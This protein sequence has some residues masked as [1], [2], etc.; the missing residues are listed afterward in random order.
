MS[1]RYG[2][3]DFEFNKINESIVNLICCSIRFLGKECTLWLDG[4]EDNKE[5]LKRFLLSNKDI[6]WICYASSAEAQCFIALGLDPVEFRWLDLYVEYRMLLNCNDK[7]RHGLQLKDGS[8]VTTEPKPPHIKNLDIEIDGWEDSKEL[9]RKIKEKQKGKYSEGDYNLAACVYK[10]LNRIIDSD[11]KTKMRDLI[12]AGGPFSEQE[13]KD[14]LNYCHDDTKHLSDLAFKIKYEQDKV[15]KVDDKERLYR[16][17]MSA[18][19]A[20]IMSYGYPVDEEKVRTLSKNIPIILFDL[21]EEINQKTGKALFT[22][23]IKKECHKVDMNVLAEAISEYDKDGSWPKT[24]T[25]KY[26]TDSETFEKIIDARHDKRE[27]VL[28]LYC[29]YK[30]LAT[31]LNS[32]KEDI[33]KK[34]NFYSALGPDGRVHSYMGQYVAQSGRFQQPAKTFIFLKDARLRYLV[35]PRAGYVITG[36]DFAQQEF[37]LAACISKDFTMYKT[38]MSGDI[39]LQF[40][41]DVGIVRKVAKAAVLGI[42]Y[43]M[44][45]NALA[46]KITNDSKIETSPEQ[47]QEIIDKFY[48]LY[49]DYAKFKRDLLVSYAQKKY[50]KLADGWTMY[51]DN[52]NKLSVLNVPIQGMGACIL[53]KAIELA[54]ERGLKI[55]FPLHDALYIESKLENYEKELDILIECMREASGF[56]FEGEVKDWAES[57]R[58]DVESWGPDLE[59]TKKHTKPEDMFKGCTFKTDKVHID[60]RVE[61]NY[62]EFLKYFYPL[63]EQKISEYKAKVKKLSFKDGKRQINFFD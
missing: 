46:R 30:N 1:E 51:G 40:G 4:R 2:S 15:F 42:N 5:K 53:R 20:K 59:P 41:S 43:G 57:I 23:N 47:A 22:W 62:D 54:T 45:K 52:K 37:L 50:L 16:G 58:L 21:C 49:S 12:I 13:K 31:S 3:I 24:R 8:V 33:V 26:C 17:K 55:I 56:Y 28:S 10:M 35:Q 60:E 18:I 38:Y 14:I 44:Q 61:E 6:V 34:D 25:G 29:H 63:S 7:F 32:M 36:I 19:V 39:Y 9:S 11:H 48:N 27:D